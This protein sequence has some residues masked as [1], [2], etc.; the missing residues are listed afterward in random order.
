MMLKSILLY[1]FTSTVVF[2]QT[3]VVS[4]TTA[5]PAGV[6]RRSVRL[7]VFVDGSK[8]ETPCS[9]TGE[10]DNDP[11]FECFVQAEAR[12][13]EFIVRMPGY[14]PYSIKVPDLDKT[15]VR[16]FAVLPLGTIHAAESDPPRI[17]HITLTRSQDGS[18]RYQIMVN[19]LAA[20]Q[21]SIA[22][23][24]MDAYLRRMPRSGGLMPSN[25]ATNFT[26]SDRLLL[27][28]YKPGKAGISATITLASDHPEF[29]FH[30]TGNGVFHPVSDDSFNL[31]APVNFTIPAH[32]FFEIE[33]L[34]P[35]SHNQESSSDAASSGANSA[36][37]LATWEVVE[38][39]SEIH[40]TLHTTDRDHPDIDSDYVAY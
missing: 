35:K 29:P 19:N 22:Q 20:K 21:I 32:E 40:F 25:P 27:T 28:P 18:L 33:L 16:G 10:A 7:A 26:I 17:D 3:K 36:K 39:F 13:G 12:S 31:S 9:L 23:I 15:E 24:N 14:K 30:V 38:R 34:I 37:T 11:M 8:A 6:L 2:G 4:V 1:L 5:I